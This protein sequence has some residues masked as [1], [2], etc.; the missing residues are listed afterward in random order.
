VNTYRALTPAAVA[1]FAD[2][3]LDLDLTKSQEADY[4]AAGLLELVPRKY[5][6]V[7]NNY[8]VPQGEAALIAGGHIERVDDKPEPE[9]SDATASEPEE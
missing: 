5:R 4:L 8:A 2:G 1:M 3:V 9:S 7:S 6:A